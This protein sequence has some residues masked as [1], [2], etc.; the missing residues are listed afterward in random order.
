M[1]NFLKTYLTDLADYFRMWVWPVAALVLLYVL[2]GQPQFLVVAYKASLVFF[3]AWVG[4]WI[5]RNLFRDSR[6]YDPMSLPYAQF[7][8]YRRAVIV[9]ATI[10]AFALAL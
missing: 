5:D 1:K 3:A 9:A 8:G 6:Y 2:Q 10:L 4:Y 7:I